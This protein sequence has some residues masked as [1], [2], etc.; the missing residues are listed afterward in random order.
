[1]LLAQLPPHGGDFQTSPA[2]FIILFAVGF[3]IGAFGHLIK[4]RTVVAVG[5]G[6][7]MLA[8]VF[9]PLYLAITR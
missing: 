9:I 6:M 4:S 2:P 8:T 3:A 5:V 7:V 1:M